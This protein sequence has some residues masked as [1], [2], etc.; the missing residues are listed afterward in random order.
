MSRGFAKPND[1]NPRLVVRIRIGMDDQQQ[2]P[3]HPRYRMVAILAALIPVI[4]HDR[5][6][7]GQNELCD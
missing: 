7:V 3:V 1:P 5:E 4:N 2:F 6:P